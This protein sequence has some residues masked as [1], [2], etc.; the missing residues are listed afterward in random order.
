M[1]V[2][3]PEIQKDEI[4][5]LQDSNF[6]PDHVCIVTG[7]GSGAIGNVSSLRTRVC[8]ANKPFYS[9]TTFDLN[10]LT[11]TMSAEGAG[12]FC[13]FSVSTGFTKIPLTLNQVPARR[14]SREG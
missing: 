9:I 4:L 2:R 8:I 11:Q 14:Q 3:E 7:C 10:A 12:E 1:D 13:S 6:N 5:V